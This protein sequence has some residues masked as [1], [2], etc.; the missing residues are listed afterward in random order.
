MPTETRLRPTKTTLVRIYWRDY[1]SLSQLAAA[2]NRTMA[3]V[4]EELVLLASFEP[5]PPASSPSPST[6]IAAVPEGGDGE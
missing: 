3:E 1:E 6:Q 2:E 4:I 5:R